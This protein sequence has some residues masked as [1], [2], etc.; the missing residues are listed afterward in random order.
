MQDEKRYCVYRHTSPNGK[1][2]IGITGRNPISRW[3]EGRGY[4]QNP[5][6]WSAI[7]KYGWD[8]FKHEVLYSTLSKDDACAIEIELISAHRS[9]NPD[10]GYNH[11]LGGDQTFYGCHH[12][13]ETKQKMSEK[14]RGRQMSKET[15]RKLR[16]ANLGKKM[17]EDVR[18]KLSDRNR[19]RRMSEISRKKMSEG[20]LRYRVV[21]MTL[22]GEILIVHPSTKVAAACIGCSRRLLTWACNDPARTAKGYRWKYESIKED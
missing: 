6:F 9:N 14:A 11:S 22:S 13:A 2:Y 17:S 10:Y 15:R 19:G 5:H 3:N 18:Q 7:Q 20:N 4:K 16:E 8:N 12:S 21:Q 1:V